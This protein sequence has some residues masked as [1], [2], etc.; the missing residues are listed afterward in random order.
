MGLQK[1]L[2]AKRADI[3]HHWMDLLIDDY[4]SDT[5]QFI[6]NQKDAFSNPVGS[7]I[8][9]ALPKLFDQLLQT[10]EPEK[11]A[12]LIDPVIRIRAAQDLS[13]SRSVGFVF[14]L[15]KIVRRVLGKQCDTAEM[16]PDMQ[17]FDEA[18]D[19][20]GL[21]AFNVFVSCR[22]KIYQLK[23]SNER[24]RIYSAFHRAGLIEEEPG[25]SGA[26]AP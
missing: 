21:V 13:P 4:P 7:S 16:Q 12:E 10:P 8:R 11:F 9:N 1:L 23:L 15:K 22:E 2:K 18:V 19:Q 3:V 25:D 26:H 5:A 24:D 17:Q 14:G 6:R 20:M